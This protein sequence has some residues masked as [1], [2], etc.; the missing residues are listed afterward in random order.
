MIRAK[1][2]STNWDA[3][4][5]FASSALETREVSGA[6]FRFA[7]CMTLPFF[8]CGMVEL[9]PMGFKKLKNANR[10]QMVFFVHYGKVVVEVAGNEFTISKGGVWQV[11]RGN[12]FFLPLIRSIFSRCYSFFLHVLRFVALTLPERVEQP[13]ET[14]REREKSVRERMAGYASYISSKRTFCATAVALCF[15]PV[16]GTCIVPFTGV[17]ASSARWHVTQPEAMPCYPAFYPVV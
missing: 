1:G 16:D 11:P 9:P 7:K 17:I 3:A 8:G 14:K 12:A 6:N 5:A 2:R 4:V 10:M 15:F 13:R